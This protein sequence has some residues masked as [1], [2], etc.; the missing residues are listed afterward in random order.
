MVVVGL[1]VDIVGSLVL[2]GECLAPPDSDCF[3]HGH[4]RSHNH[5]LCLYLLVFY[6]VVL[7][8]SLPGDNQTA[9]Y[10]VVVVAFVLGIL[11]GMVV[12]AYPEVAYTVVAG[13]LEV[14]P[15]ASCLYYCLPY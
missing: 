1:V 12:V 9:I 8:D 10:A 2:D 6:L 11:L 7:V 5:G 4:V 15:L 3:V 13:M 14:A